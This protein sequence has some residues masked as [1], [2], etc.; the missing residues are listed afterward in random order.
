MKPNYASVRQSMDS[1]H[2]DRH[3]MTKK[4]AAAPCSETAGAKKL[5]KFTETCFFACKFGLN[6]L[7]VGGVVREKP[8]LRNTIH[9]D[10]A[11]D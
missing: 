11:V 4:V 6:R 5:E 2:R 10:G 3:K 1:L 8:L 9:V 7:R